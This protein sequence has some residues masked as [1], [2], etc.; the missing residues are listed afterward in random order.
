MT[1]NSKS[2]C[3]TYRI[4]RSQLMAIIIIV[5]D[6][7]E[8]G[9]AA[10]YRTVGNNTIISARAISCLERFVFNRRITYCDH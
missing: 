2:S 4:H 7:R 10:K 6:W 8:S 5:N 3:K 1:A 9:R